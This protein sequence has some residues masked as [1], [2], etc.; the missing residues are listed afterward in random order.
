MEIIKINSKYKLL[1]ILFLFSIICNCCKKIEK[2]EFI[3]YRGPVKKEHTEVLKSH[4]WQLTRIY[5]Y[6]SKNF[7][8]ELDKDIIRNENPQN[9]FIEF[10]EKGIYMNNKFVGNAKYNGEIFSI[11]G[12][13][14]LTNNY[15]LY[16]LKGNNLI[17]QNDV[18]YLKKN[19]FI[20]QYTIQLLLTYKPVVADL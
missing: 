18:G 6:N 20:K 13:D 1:L 3:G 10:R 19:K 16:R 14:T 2:K 4:K 7:I 12:I 11:K 8:V 9:K 5:V 17:L 15:F